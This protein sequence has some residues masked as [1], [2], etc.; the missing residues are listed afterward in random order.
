MSEK[1]HAELKVFL[2]HHRSVTLAYNDADGIGACGLWYV[3]D[4]DLNLYYLSSPVTR[5]GRALLNGGDVAF[6][7]HRDEQDW[8]AIQGL[9]GKGRCGPLPP[10]QTPRIW[11][12]YVQ[13]YPFVL[14]QFKDIDAALKNT[15]F[16][17]LKPTWMRL[18]D[19]TK[20]FGYKQGIIFPE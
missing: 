18:I 12:L 9:Q 1:L 11:R 3:F 2:S 13:R 4:D 20:G 16:W 10:A 19:N 17:Q 7:I 8:H 14:Q 15:L 6:T 5:H